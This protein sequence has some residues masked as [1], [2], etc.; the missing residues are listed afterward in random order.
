MKNKRPYLSPM[1]WHH[2][3]MI[4]NT[5]L[6]RHSK[7]TIMKLFEDAMIELGYLRRTRF[8]F[9]KVTEKGKSKL[10][11]KYKAPRVKFKVPTEHNN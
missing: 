9:L 4:N 6:V 1:V 5:I 7:D 2:L 11:E 10:S 3:H 8:G